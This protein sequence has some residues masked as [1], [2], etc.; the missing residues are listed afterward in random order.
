MRV[1][2]LFSFLALITILQSCS[3]DPGYWK[4]EQISSGKRADFHSLNEQALKALKA[5][6]P[7]QLGFL[8][9]KELI[10]DSYNISKID[11][12]SNSLNAADYSVVN[13]Y[14][15][16]NKY[17]DYDTINVT[18]PDHYKIVYPGTARE[19]Y[20]AFF[21]PKTG[22]N[23]TLIT[24]TYAKLSYGWKVISLDEGPYT[25]NGKTAP[26]LFKLAQAEYN[27]G[28][29]VNAVNNMQLA[30]T[31]VKP[32]GI[33]EYPDESDMNIFYARISFE[34]NKKYKFPVVIQQVPTHPRIFRIFNS[35]A[36]SGGYA[37][38]IYYLSSIKLAD[39]AGLRRENE[40]IK[41]VISQII[42]GIDKDN[43]CLIY[44][45]FNEMPKV[46]KSVDRFEMD[47][48]LQ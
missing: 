33:W 6:D 30:N 48:K 12:I 24:L 13:E 28:Y 43:K 8:E 22:D 31:S 11:H 41:K 44:I 39:T 26:R 14:Y 20:I 34:A 1:T 38:A 5:N 46:K 3:S 9:A 27:K 36:S 47:D 45:A 2:S 21:L 19:M 40:L 17:K 23:K 32:A 7:A 4:N 18:S 15:A 29:L 42:P 16:V 10:D 37:P 35:E 25:I